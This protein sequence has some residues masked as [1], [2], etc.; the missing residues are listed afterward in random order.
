VTVGEDVPSPCLQICEID[1]ARG[2]CRGCGRS[3]AEIEAWPS[4]TADER[5]AILAQLDKRQRQISW[6]T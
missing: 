6:P 2:W 4:A 5:R 1:P 3:L